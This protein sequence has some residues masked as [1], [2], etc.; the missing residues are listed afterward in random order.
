MQLVICVGVGIGGYVGFEASVKWMG[1]S[2]VR[3]VGR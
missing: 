1:R 2:S 3:S